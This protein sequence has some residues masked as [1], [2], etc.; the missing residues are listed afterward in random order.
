V[1]QARGQ[2][3]GAGRG[4][5]HG[6]AGAGAAAGGQKP[7]QVRG[8]VRVAANTCS[9]CVRVGGV[10][11]ARSS[12]ENRVLLPANA[13]KVAGCGK[14]QHA[15]RHRACTAKAVERVLS[16]SAHVLF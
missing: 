14:L 1:R 6:P 7:K 5:T 16:S 15:V 12:R 8:D 9:H 2:G 3:S 10:K 11:G 4:H 13:S